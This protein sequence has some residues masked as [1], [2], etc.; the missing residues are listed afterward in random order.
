DVASF[1]EQ[2]F[3][4]GGE[5]DTPVRALEQLNSELSLESLDLQ[6]Q[7]EPRDTELPRRSPEVEFFGD[8]DEV[9]ELPQFQL[10]GHISCVSFVIRQYIG[11]QSAKATISIVN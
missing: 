9:A 7:R 8:G 11:K 5:L 4:G 6:T 2:R 10:L 1:L 3:P